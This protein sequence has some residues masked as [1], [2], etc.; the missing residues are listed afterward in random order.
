MPQ[1]LGGVELAFFHV[2]FAT[3]VEYL[4]LHGKVIIDRINAH[5]NLPQ[6]QFLAIIRE[7]RD[8]PIVENCGSEF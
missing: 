3:G 8:D 7:R 2:V 4:V 6:S 1:T 5:H